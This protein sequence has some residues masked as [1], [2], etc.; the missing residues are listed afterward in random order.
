MARAAKCASVTGLAT[1]WLS[2][3]TCL[4]TVV[5]ISCDH[6]RILL[7]DF[8]TSFHVMSRTS[9]DGFPLKDIEK[10]FMLDLI[11]RLSIVCNKDS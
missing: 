4:K 8:K 6:H 9:L 10:D 2:V 11:K 1:A 5:P 3:S 7:N